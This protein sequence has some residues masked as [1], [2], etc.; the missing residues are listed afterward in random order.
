M[1]L[2]VS[3]QKESLVAIEALRAAAGQTALSANVRAQR[4]VALAARRDDGLQSGD[5]GQASL[6]TARAAALAEELRARNTLG[7]LHPRGEHHNGVAAQARRASSRRVEIVIEAHEANVRADAF[8]AARRAG[9]AFA[10]LLE[11]AVVALRFAAL[12]PAVHHM[13]IIALVAPLAI[14]AGAALSEHLLVIALHAVAASAAPAITAIRIHHAASVR[15]Q[16]DVLFALIARAVAMLVPRALHAADRALLAAAL[17]VH[18]VAVI[19]LVL[20]AASHHRWAV[21]AVA[22][23]AL[24]AVCANSA[25]CSIAS[26]SRLSESD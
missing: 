12:A 9:V 26:R 21:G 4:A 22:L 2:S 19:A 13:R 3:A 17:V 20:R 11:L 8:L 24:V 18:A 15:V 5:A 6:G 1:A 7:L 25:G 14:A 23:I 10:V 16:A